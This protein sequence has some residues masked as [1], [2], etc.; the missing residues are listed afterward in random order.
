MGW[1]EIFTD[2]LF[3]TTCNWVSLITHISIVE[4]FKL[5]IPLKHMAGYLS[6]SHMQQGEMQES[7]ATRGNAGDYATQPTVHEEKDEILFTLT[8]VHQ[9]TILLGR[10]LHLLE[11]TVWITP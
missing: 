4:L 2:W 10:E 3:C 1:V 8:M 5:I 6:M 7:H 9:N 11:N